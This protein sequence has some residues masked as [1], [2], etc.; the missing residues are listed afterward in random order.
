MNRLEFLLSGNHNLSLPDVT[1][2]ITTI[3][4]SL[5]LLTGNHNLSLPDVTHVIPTYRE[6]QPQSPRC[7][8]CCYYYTTIIS[9]SYREQL[10]Q[11]QSLRCW[12]NHLPSGGVLL[13]MDPVPYR[14]ACRHHI[15]HLT[16]PP[17]PLKVTD[18][19][20]EETRSRL[21]V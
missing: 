19:D 21:H 17:G 12:C 18:E 16:P 7:Y 11:L 13:R 14:L 1:H 5:L 20:L 3:L 15:Q 4:L 6:P 2:V 9:T 10:I 8:S